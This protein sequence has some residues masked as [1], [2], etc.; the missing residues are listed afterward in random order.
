[1]EKSRARREYKGASI[2]VALGLS[3][4]AL[5]SRKP[6]AAAFLLPRGFLNNKDISESF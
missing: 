6:E 2:E 5:I 4:E 3:L 1:M